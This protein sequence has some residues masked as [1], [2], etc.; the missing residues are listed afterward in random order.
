MLTK[1]W[2]RKIALLIAL[3]VFLVIAP[4]LILYTKGYRYDLKNKAFRKIGMIIIESVPKNV[5]VFLDGEYKSDKTPVKIKNLFPGEYSIKVTK[6]GFSFWEKKI[7]VESQ[8]VTW[9][10]N[11][12]LF[13]QNPEISLVSENV[14]NFTISPNREKIIFLSLNKKDPG[15]F[16]INPKT[17][18]K[19]KIFPKTTLD[20]AKLGSTK[21]ILFSDLQWDSRSEKIILSWKKEGKKYFAIVNLQTKEI[22]FLDDLFDFNIENVK[23]D[24]DNNKIYLTSQNTLYALDL[25]SKSLS[26]YI[27]SQVADYEIATDEI[28]CLAKLP[29]SLF[30]DIKNKLQDNDSENQIRLIKIN[31]TNTKEKKLINVNLPQSKDSIISLGKNKEE[32]ILFSPK[33]K[34]LHLINVKEKKSE[35]VGKNVKKFVWSPSKKKLLF[36]GN[37][38]VWFYVFTKEKKE[39]KIQKYKLNTP[40][41]IARYGKEIK[42]VAWYPDEEHVALLLENSI[43]IIELDD[44][45]RRNFYELPK[46]FDAKDYNLGFDK[47]GENIYLVKKENSELLKIK[48][49]EI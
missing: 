26:S 5:D 19:S 34:K 10:S 29:N 24:V 2:E 23:W 8:L 13:Y 42:N 37:H 49:I 46:N 48:I 36:W 14:Q 11:I 7:S 12:K 31:K 22:I 38:E 27:I 9:A 28:F 33:D 6:E 1:R 32:L 4:T 44:R 18:E 41:L 3:I 45:D 21:N 47:K 40:N 43:K 17:R 15:L 39:S 35:L 30:F 20:V 16:L 25:I